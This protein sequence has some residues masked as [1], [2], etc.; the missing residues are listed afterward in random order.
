MQDA[1]S[2]CRWLD[3][4]TRRFL[5]SGLQADGGEIIITVDSLAPKRMSHQ[6][7][8]LGLG[9]SLADAL[10]GSRVLRLWLPTCRTD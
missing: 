6:Q 3:A 9:I 7:V 8:S 4:S 2:E 5:F 1:D 10:H